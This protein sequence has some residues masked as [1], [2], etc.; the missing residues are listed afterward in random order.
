M[1]YWKSLQGGVVGQSVLTDGVVDSL[2]STPL[3]S[4]LI[5]AFSGIAPTDI[6]SCIVMVLVLTANIGNHL[7]NWQVKILAKYAIYSVESIGKE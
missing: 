5:V 1:F 7:R 4:A 6:A 3:C 2:N